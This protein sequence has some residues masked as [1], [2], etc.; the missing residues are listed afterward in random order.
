M[1]TV[2]DYTAIVSDYRW[3]DYSHGDQTVVTYKYNDEV[4]EHWRYFEDSSMLRTFRSAE[5]YRDKVET[6]IQAWEGASGLQLIEVGADE[7]ADI[8]LGVFDL[9]KSSVHDHAS[10]Y[11][12]YPGSYWQI[13]GD[14]FIDWLEAHEVHLW[15]HE[16]GHALGLE[17]PHDGDI[18]LDSTVD[19]VSRTVMSYNGRWVGRLGDLDKEA[20]SHIYGDNSATNLYVSAHELGIKSVAEV[21]QQIRDYDGNMLGGVSSWKRFGGEMD[22]QGDGDAEFLFVN[23]EIGRWATLGPDDDGFVFFGNHGAGGDTRVVGIY[24]DPLVQSGDVVKGSDHDSQRRFSNDISLDNLTP[25]TAGDFDRDGFQN[26]YFRT[27]DGTAFLN[28]IMHAD[29]NIQYANY[30]SYDQMVDFLS[31]NGWSSD[32]WDG[33]QVA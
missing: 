27:N 28:A 13:A 5:R 20:I 24:I 3:W 29:G 1:P 30:Q 9:S 22:V 15:M 8:E 32:V 10:G 16:I 6:A 25:L 7:E 18:I 2:S 31:S 23:P 14:V 19:H 33:W 12:Y 11:A 26:L 21:M 4:A 17:H